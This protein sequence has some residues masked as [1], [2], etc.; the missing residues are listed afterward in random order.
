MTAGDYYI[1][2]GEVPESISIMREAANWL[3]DTGRPM[4]GLDELTSERIKNPPEEF[5]VL[6]Y[7][8]ESA[9]TLTLSFEDSFFWPEI[10]FGNSGF[11]HKLAVRRRFAGCGAAKAL[12]EHCAEI[13][14]TKNIHTLRLDCDPHRK[15][16]CDFYEKCG[17]ILRNIKTIHTKLLGDIDVAFYELFF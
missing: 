12:I 8:S 13:C 4:W 1:T 7:E 6:R 5:F 11:I 3:I 15:G 2:T 10:P 16:L 17:F 9:A 14:K